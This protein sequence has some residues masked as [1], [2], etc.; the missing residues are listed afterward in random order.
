MPQIRALSVVLLLIIHHASAEEAALTEEQ[1]V[2]HFLNRFSLGAT[3]E[4]VSEVRRKGI[5]FWLDA[6]LAAMPA[7]SPDL[8]RRLATFDSLKMTNRGVMKRYVQPLPPGA[9]IKEIRKRN[10]ERN[11]PR[12]ELKDSVVLRAVY[13]RHQVRE[14]AGDFF[15]NHFCVAV[16]KGRVRYYATDYER[17]VIRKNVFGKFGDM[18]YGSAK[19]PAMLVYL[20]NV[21]SRRPPTKAELK[22]VEMRVR[23]QTKSKGAG[24]EASDIAA[25]RGLNENYARELLELHTL[26]VDNYYTQRDVENVAAALTGWTVSNDPERPH[27]FE[28]RRDM[29]VDEDNV[30]LNRRIARNKKNPL[31]EGEKILDRLIRHEGT[32]RFLAWKLCRYF[33]HDNPPEDLVQRI[34]EVFKKSDGH[35]PTVYVAIVTDP[36][37]FRPRNYRAKFKRPFEFVVSALRVTKA[38]VKHVRGIHRTLQAMSEDLYVCKDPTGYYDQAEAWRDPGAFAVR[39]KFAHDLV[40]NKVPG[41]AV[42]ASL[43]GGLTPRNVERWKEILVGR[44]LPGGLGER[45][46]GVIDRMVRAYLARNE[47]LKVAELAPR[48]AALILGSPEFQQQ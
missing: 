34:A 21:V 36:E 37:F 7:E 46:S 30:F 27:E 1:K 33:V 39:W 41:V 23:L 2:I 31:A 6:Q 10:R 5:R 44:L 18:L 40:M 15:R 14:V 4:L 32:A 48:L 12:I 25:Q 42:P 38:D 35:L 11:I 29:H 9:G 16:D 3:P 13:G 26:G 24:R 45:T 47:S 20:D 8:D 19:H 22:K 43:Y 28:F 17:E